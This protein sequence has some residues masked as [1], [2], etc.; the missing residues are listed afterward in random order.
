MSNLDNLLH[1]AKFLFENRRFIESATT[2]SYAIEWI[3]NIDSLNTV[4]T[5]MRMCYF[6]GNDVPRAFDIIE[7]QEKLPVKQD[8]TIIRDKTNFLRYL[9]RHDEAH[10]LAKTISDNPTR[11]LALG[12]FEH[13]AGNIKRAFELTELA[14]DKKYWWNS[15]PNYDYSYWRGNRVENL[16]IKSESGFGDQII[17]ARWIPRLKEICNNIWYDGNGLE[18]VFCRNFGIKEIKY[19]TEMDDLHIV[20]IMSL[21][22]ILGVDTPDPVQYLT[23][24]HAIRERYLKKYPKT[25]TR[26]GLCVQSESTHIET[27]LRTLPLGKMLDVL[28]EHGEVMNLQKEIVDRDVRMC[29]TPLNTWEDT[30]ALI[31]TCDYIVTCDTGVSHAAAS[32]GKTTIVLMHAAAYFTWNHNE[33]LSK[34]QW[35][36][37]AWC[38]HQDVPCDWD[39][40]IK[41]CSKLITE[42]EKGK[43]N[44]YT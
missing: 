14:R 26:I 30:L 12:W 34:T 24:D 18:S 32:M 13:K 37:N 28:I 31:D 38:I 21:P 39:G 44:E 6:L 15:E 16:V 23:S 41:K 2:L 11:N 40:A 3:D 17:F 25:K 4:Y 33:D 20:P 35:Y 19:C 1:G 43:R 8:W 29:Y 5:N 7:K 36:Q 9:N 27:T 10:E 22:Y 42:F